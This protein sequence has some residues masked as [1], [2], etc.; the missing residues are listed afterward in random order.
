VPKIVDHGERRIEIVKAA[1]RIIASD[2]F[3][4]ATMREIAAEAGYTHGAVKPY[5]ASKDELLTFA[6]TFVFTQTNAR[7]TAATA[8]LT[9][10][11]ALRAFCLEILP[12]DEVK[13]TEAR[14]VIP[15]WHRALNDPASR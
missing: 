2:G 5:F 3:D 9:G 1:W 11:K 8:R 6:F 10:L 13:L 12:T 15:F 4:R 7:M 14:I